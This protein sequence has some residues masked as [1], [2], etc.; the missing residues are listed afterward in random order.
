MIISANANNKI[1]F[2][3]IT[4]ITATVPQKGTVSLTSLFPASEV[5]LLGLEANPAYISV[6]FGY[7]TSEVSANYTAYYNSL[8][9]IFPVRINWLT[10]YSTN[11]SSP[12][13]IMAI[14]GY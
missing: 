2:E 9:S 1:E 11:D 14:I 13:A 7:Q 4:T 12:Y 6:A 10:A 5:Y 3:H 8:V